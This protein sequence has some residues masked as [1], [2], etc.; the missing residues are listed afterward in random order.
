MPAADDEW[1][2]SDMVRALIR[3]EGKV[4]GLITGLPQT[5]VPAVLWE[6][7]N[8]HVDFVH[9]GLGREIGDLRTEIRSRRV[10]WWSVGALG[11]SAIALVLSVADRLYGA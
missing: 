9:S 7:R 11:V 8:R 5:Y 2:Q 10:P 6:Q 4:D 3:I 1:S